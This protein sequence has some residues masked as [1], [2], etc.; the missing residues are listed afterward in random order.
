MSLTLP[1]VLAQC[2]AVLIIILMAI[3]AHAKTQNSFLSFQVIINSLYIPHYVLLFA[4]TAVATS[5]ICVIRTVIFYLYQ[6]NGKDVPM[7]LLSVIFIVVVGAGMIVWE[8]WYSVFPILAT[9]IY[10]YGQWQHDVRTSRKTVIAGD[11]NW[12]VYNMF[13]FGYVS[14]VGKFVEIISCSIALRK[15]VKE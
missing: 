12:V 10:T 6:K 7:W 2:V 5:I 3:G 13:C 11:L 8:A 4:D 1:W 9:I 15:S 14:L